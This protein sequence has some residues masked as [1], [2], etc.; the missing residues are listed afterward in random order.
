MVLKIA[1]STGKSLRKIPTIPS[2]REWPLSVAFV[3][4]E[5]SCKSMAGASFDAA[6][7]LGPRRANVQAANGIQLITV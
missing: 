2:I 3:A 5:A 6:R 1:A 7:Q 4:P